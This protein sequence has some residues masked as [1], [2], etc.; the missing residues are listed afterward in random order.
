MAGKIHPMP[1]ASPHD[2]FEGV[3]DEGKAIV[4]ETSSPALQIFNDFPIQSFFDSILQERAILVQPQN[5]PIVVLDS[6]T[7]NKPVSCYGVANDPMSDTPIC[8]QFKSGGM[9]VGSSGY[10]VAPGKIVR[11]HGIKPGQDRNASGAVTVGLPAGFLGGG[12]ATYY[13]LLTPDA[14]VEFPHTTPEVLVHRIRLPIIAGP[15]PAISDAAGSWFNWPLNFPWRNG[16]NLKN[17]PQAGQGVG[18]FR[19]TRVEFRIRSTALVG[20]EQF[21]AVMRGSDSFDTGAD[22][23]T[24]STAQASNMQALFAPGPDPTGVTFPV[25]GV[26]DG[27]LCREGGDFARVDLVSSNAALIGQFVDIVRYGVVG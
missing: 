2:P 10:I 19:V 15:L 16:R 12:K 7:Q 6:K 1:L 17:Q 14:C 26:T 25:L 11:P 3:K 13:L 4:G 5:N 24:V 22:G 9:K 21:F 20:G 8:V 18:G 27:P 23:E